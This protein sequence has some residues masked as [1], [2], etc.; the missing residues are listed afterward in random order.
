MYDQFLKRADTDV[1][2]ALTVPYLQES[3]WK[4]RYTRDIKKRISEILFALFDVLDVNDD[5]YLDEDEH[6][7]WFHHLGVSDT[8]FTK[9]TFNAIDVNHDGKLS[10]QEYVDGCYDFFFS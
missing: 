3:V 7:R 2:S 6:R 8:S 5:G 1:K 4:Q 9:D 10:F